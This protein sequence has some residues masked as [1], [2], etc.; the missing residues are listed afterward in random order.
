MTELLLEIFTLTNK[1]ERETY[2]EM[3]DGIDE[4]WFFY[5]VIWDIKEGLPCYNTC[6]IN[7]N[8]DITNFFSN[9]ARNERNMTWIEVLNFSHVTFSLILLKLSCGMHN[10]SVYG[11]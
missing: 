1:N 9:L 4:K 8:G 2:P 7:E 5:H 10:V 3:R 6:I 11:R